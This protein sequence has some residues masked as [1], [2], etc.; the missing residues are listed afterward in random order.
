MFKKFLFALTSIFSLTYSCNVLSFSGGGSFGIN[1]VAILD[2]LSQNNLIPDFDI[3]TGISAGGLNAGY[4]NFFDDISKGID[5]LK[6]IYF[7]IKNDDV[8]HHDFLNIFKNY[9]VLNNTPLEKTITNMISHLQ[10]TGDKKHTLIGATNVLTGKLDIFPFHTL[11]LKDKINVLMATTAIP[12]VFSPRII[13]ETIYVDGGT[14]ENEIIVPFS[15]NCQN[16]NIYL[17][18]SHDKFKDVDNIDNFFQYSKRILDIVSNNFDEEI[19]KIRYV[20]DNHKLNITYCFPNSSLLNKYSILDFDKGK[21]LYEL[22]YNNF[23]CIPNY[24]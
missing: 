7:N 16:Y 24:C 12:F 17:I 6:N 23:E 21:E 19:N 4:L 22:T 10:K 9:G 20:C 8:Y 14:L 2:N 1:E 3:I 11:S 18:N 15:E 13:N 5:G